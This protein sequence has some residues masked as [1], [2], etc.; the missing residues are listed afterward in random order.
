MS[1]A[2]TAEAAT[3]A[4]P[5]GEDSAQAEAS[6]SGLAVCRH[7]GAEDEGF[8]SPEQCWSPEWICGAKVTPG[9]R[10][11]WQLDRLT[12]DRIRRV[13]EVQ[14]FQFLSLLASVVLC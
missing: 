9:K 11:I 6:D 14:H 8:F 2:S 10:P 4:T 13:W 12:D 3:T 5:A 1:S 7:E